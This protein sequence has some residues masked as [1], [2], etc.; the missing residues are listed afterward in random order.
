[1]VAAVD[2]VDF[3]LPRGKACSV[4]VSGDRAV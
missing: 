2:G 4:I 3:R 1:V